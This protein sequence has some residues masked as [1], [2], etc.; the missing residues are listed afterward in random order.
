LTITNIIICA[1]VALTLAAVVVV[2][3]RRA[4]RAK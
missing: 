1:V 2:L 4:Q 3:V